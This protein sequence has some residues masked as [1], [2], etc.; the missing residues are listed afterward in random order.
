MAKVRIKIGQR[1]LTRLNNVYTHFLMSGSWI[2]KI[3]H[4]EIETVE[5]PARKK[6]RSGKIIEEAKKVKYVTEAKINS[7]SKTG[8]FIGTHT[9]T[10]WIQSFLTDER[11]MD[12]RENWLTLIDQLRT[13]GFEITFPPEEEIENAEDDGKEEDK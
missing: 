2:Y 12:W 3:E 7:Y 6:R 9:D 4:L 10:V 1:E 8:R 13:W 11:M 5:Q